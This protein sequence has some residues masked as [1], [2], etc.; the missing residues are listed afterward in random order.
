M[1]PPGKSARFNP[2]RWSD[3]SGL[4]PRQLD[5]NSEECKALARKIDNIRKDIEKR[6]REHAENP[7]KLPESVPGGKPRE[8][9]EGH[10]GLIKD[11]EAILAQR[12]AE[13]AAKCGGQQCPPD[14]SAIEDMAKMLGVSVG[15]YLLI[16]EGSRLFPPR[17]AIPI[18]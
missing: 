4:G 5:P 3:P 6:R 17:N 10:L 9:R 13:Y 14:T 16:S 8:S 11:L 18:P 1:E 12:E 2:L 7:G 15:T